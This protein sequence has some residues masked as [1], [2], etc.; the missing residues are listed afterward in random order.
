MTGFMPSRSSWSGK[1]KD[2]NDVE[3]VFGNVILL[4]P[5]SFQVYISVDV[6]ILNFSSCRLNVILL[7][8]K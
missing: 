3:C 8:L 2:A 4:I 1:G 5:D 6:M 7:S